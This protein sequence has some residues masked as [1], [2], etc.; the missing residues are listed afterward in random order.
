MV[1]ITYYSAVPVSTL[2][3]IQSPTFEQYLH[4]QAEQHS[5]PS[6]SCLCSTLAV[7]YEKFLQVHYIPHPLCFS[8]FIQILS[9]PVRQDLNTLTFDFRFTASPFFRSFDV[10]CQ[11][12]IEHINNRLLSF[13][14]SL[15][16]ADKVPAREIFY[17]AMKGISSTMK[18]SIA[19]SFV[20]PLA[21]ISSM[22]NSNKLMSTSFTNFVLVFEL[23][24]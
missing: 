2:H 18:L 3:H 8:P 10:L 13:N 21:L 11:I 22:M 24:Y 17:A 4:V 20:N 15:F 1:L 19:S 9:S 12:S 7:P 6:F 16:L 5:N 23:D 14:T